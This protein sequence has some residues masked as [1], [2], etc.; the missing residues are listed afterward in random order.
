VRV[1]CRPATALA[2]ACQSRWGVVLTRAWGWG[3]SV[4]EDADASGD[5]IDAIAA[6]SLLR[7]RVYDM[8]QNRIKA[9]ICYQDALRRDVKCYQGLG[10]RW[11]AHPVRMLLLSMNGGRRALEGTCL[12]HR[13]RRVAHG[14]VRM[15]L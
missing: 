15:R 6:M 5:E 4:D 12:P 13:L 9:A 1:S 2:D 11:R 14:P 8:Q 3:W 10:P 7:G